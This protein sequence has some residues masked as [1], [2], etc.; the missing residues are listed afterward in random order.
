MYTKWN[1]RISCTVDDDTTDS[2]DDEDENVVLTNRTTVSRD[3][4]NNVNITEGTGNNIENI[5]SSDNESEVEEN[6][7]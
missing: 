6:T 2:D 5:P 1:K 3:N 7:H 4:R